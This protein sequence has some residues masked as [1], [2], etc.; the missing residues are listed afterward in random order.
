MVLARHQ[1]MVNRNVEGRPLERSAY[2]LISRLEAEGPMSIGQLADAFM[3]D[4]STVN[5][6]VAALLRG[7]LAERIVDPDGGLARKLRATEEG[8][9]RLAADRE[10]HRRGLERVLA[11]WDEP[12]RRELLDVLTRF[13]RSIEDL[14]GNA[15]PR[16]DLATGAGSRD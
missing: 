5:R 10:R 11:D 9:R 15:W 3:L 14:Q 12:E 4:T 2:L 6:Q 7:G 8:R 13:N 16:P 1:V